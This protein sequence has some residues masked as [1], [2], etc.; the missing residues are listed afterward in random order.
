MVLSCS[1]VAMK[2]S[3]LGERK[4][5]QL[6]SK[7]LSKG[8]EVVGIGDDCAAFRFKDDYLLVST[9]MISSKT[10]IPKSMTPWQMGWFIVAINLSDVAA[11]GGKPLGF[12]LS[13]GL[14]KNTTD[15]FLKEI[16]RGA[17]S[18]AR[19][20][21]L[22]IVGGDTKENTD[23]TL[24]GTVFGF[25]KKDCFMPRKGCKPD[26]IVAVT[27]DLG[28]AGAGYYA[29]QK[30]IKNKKIIN[31]L[32]E[33]KPRIKA[34]MI[35]ANEKIVTSCMD[36][37]DGLSSSLYQLMDLNNVGFEIEKEKIP[38]SP[39]LDY[40]SKTNDLDVYDYALHFGG[41]YELLLTIPSDKF[42]KTKRCMDSIGISLKIIGSVTKQKK[43]LL[44]K[45]GVKKTLKNKGYE[46]FKKPFFLI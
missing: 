36:I 14:P 45:K 13:L 11:K 20:Y 4:A 44:V 31:G 43:V 8:D 18:C 19:K 37:S 2:L 23:I 32:L 10:H 28:R 22:S 35:L 29:I 39:S 26:D 3:D 25:V 34:G 24:C 7:I 30:D 15:S 27:G 9:D 46:H 6:I 12:V 17:N 33:P 38:I 21:G 40:L 41:D 16:M 42:E 1:K 5:I